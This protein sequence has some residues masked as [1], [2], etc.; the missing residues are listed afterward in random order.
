MKNNTSKKPKKA[1]KKDWIILLSGMAISAILLLTFPAHRQPTLSALQD[2]SMEMFAIIPAVMILMGLFSAWVS[3]EQV[4]KYL[5]SEAGFKGTALA[6]LFG[7][8]PTG[9]LYI[10]FP[11]AAVL[12]KKGVSTSNLIIFL[13][14]WACIKIPQEMVEWQFLGLRFMAVRLA[15]TIVLVILMGFVVEFIFKRTKPSAHNNF[16]GE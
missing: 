13:S 5:G 2:F 4:V 11:L 10:A 1:V 12:R 16:T 7:A 14:A 15:L 9:P 6:L 3:K 8:F